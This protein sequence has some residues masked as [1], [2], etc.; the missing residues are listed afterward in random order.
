MK[1]IVF[2]SN[3][4]KEIERRRKKCSTLISLFVGYE[5]QQELERRLWFC[6]DCEEC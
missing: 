6:E 5:T 4:Q 2:I 1:K 3:S